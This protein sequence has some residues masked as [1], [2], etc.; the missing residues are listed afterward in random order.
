MKAR[1]KTESIERRLA[2][3]EVPEARFRPDMEH[4]DRS[5]QFSGELLKLALA[6][7]AVVGFLLVNFPKDRLARIF[8]D[9]LLKALFS[10]SVISFALSAGFALLHRFYASSANFHH[11][12][13][14]KLLLL[15]DSSLGGEVDTN[16]CMREA[17]FQQCHAF[18]R[19][20]SGLLVFGA[21][22]LAGAFIRLM[23]SGV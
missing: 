9:T 5:L 15:K 2:Q 21:S 23:F 13:V 14:I 22:L 4:Y 20:T 17:K 10:A 19:I 12:Q 6:G 18:L 16:L 3:L 1:P 7:I 8:D 11:L